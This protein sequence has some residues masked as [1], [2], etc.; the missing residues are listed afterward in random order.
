MWNDV[1]A[2]IT[3]V[4]LRIVARLAL[5]DIR[6]VSDHRTHLLLGY[7]VVADH[8]HRRNQIYDLG[9]LRRSPAPSGA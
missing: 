7:E 3:M 4:A 6:K 1:F 2:Q 8:P 5:A 9:A